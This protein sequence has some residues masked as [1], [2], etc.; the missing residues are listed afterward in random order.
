MTAADKLVELIHITTGVAAVIHKP[1]NMFYLTEGYTGEGVVF[2]SDK[3]RVIITD[4]RYTEQ[5]ERQAPS[6][7]VVMVDKNIN[8]NQWIRKLTEEET[9][10]ELRFEADELSVDSF[11]RLRSAVGEELNYVPLKGAPE[12]IRQIKTATEIVIMRKAGDITTEAF[13]AILPKIRE[14]MTEKELQIE[15]DFIDEH[16][17]GMLAQ[18]CDRVVL[19]KLPYM[20]ILHAV[21]RILGKQVRDESALA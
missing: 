12:I 4:F 17:F 19:G 20:K 9:I 7:E 11:E 1:S 2:I 6:F 8:H 15:L 3:R 5:A 14:G 21:H 16:S 18:E 10:N 13:R